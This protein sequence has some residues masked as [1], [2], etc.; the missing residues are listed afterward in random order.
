MRV[1]ARHE[2]FCVWAVECLCL[3]V[4]KVSGFCRHLFLGNGDHRGEE[5][6]V[7]SCFLRVACLE[8]MLYNIQSAGVM[9]YRHHPL[10]PRKLV[11]PA[12][13]YTVQ[14]TIQKRFALAASGAVEYCVGGCG[15]K[16][17]Y[18]SPQTCL[19]S[20]SLLFNRKQYQAR[21]S[22]KPCAFR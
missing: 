7:E 2:T 22:A 20:G 14:L 11:S 5:Y 12:S 10:K 6:G 17:C 18:G 13:M 8:H 9:H 3:P 15:G 21:R 4:G 16:A 19:V 1:K